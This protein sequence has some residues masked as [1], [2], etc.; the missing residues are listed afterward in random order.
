MCIRD[1]LVDVLHGLVG[2]VL[3]PED[4]LAVVI[5]EDEG[6]HLGLV[7]PCGAQ[8]EQGPVIR[9][10]PAE[11]EHDQEHHGAARGGGHIVA[12]AAADAHHDG[13]ED[14]HGVPGILDG[15]LLYTSRCV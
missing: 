6:L 1:R 14:V 5:L 9:A 10:Q 15:C 7:H 8:D 4:G 13:P 12:G 11:E 3:C 2:G